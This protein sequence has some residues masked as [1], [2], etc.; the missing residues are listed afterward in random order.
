[1]ANMGLADL[2]LVDPVADPKDPKA[3]AM[4]THGEAVLRAARKVADFSDAVAD[5]AIVVATSARSGGVFRRQ[6]V[7]E[8]ADVMAKVVPVLRSGGR[9]ALVFGPEPTGLASELTSRCHF[10]IHIPTVEDNASLNVAQAVAICLYELRQTWR[11]S[12]NTPTEAEGTFAPFADQERCF[13]HLEEAFREIGFLFGERADA[14]MHAVR[15]LLGRANMTP[16]EVKILLG[17]ARQIRWF[18]DQHE[19][20]KTADPRP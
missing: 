6:T 12:E 16:M 18:A 9:A 11:A 4:S 10:L 15:H 14:L 17:L 5:C 20:R 13:H 8:P 2:V 7:A 19:K 3:L 1:M